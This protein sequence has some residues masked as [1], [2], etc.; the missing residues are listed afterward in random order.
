MSNPFEYYRIESLND[1]K[2]NPSCSV[3]NLDWHAD[4]TLMVNGISWR[5]IRRNRLKKSA[6]MTGLEEHVFVRCDN[7]DCNGR[8]NKGFHA[9]CLRRHGNLFLHEIH[10]QMKHHT[11]KNRP[12]ADQVNPGND[13]SQRDTAYEEI[14]HIQRIDHQAGLISPFDKDQREMPEGP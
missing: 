5:L 1:L 12:V 2:R 4:L 7:D 6:N 9:L 10:K 8:H 3:R 13:E 11:G 14:N